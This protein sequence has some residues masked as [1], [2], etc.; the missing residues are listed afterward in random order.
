MTLLADG[1]EVARQSFFQPLAPQACATCSQV[2]LVP[3]DF[4]V[5]L[6]KV[7][8]RKLSVAIEVPHLKEFGAAFPL[9]QAGN[10]TINARLLLEET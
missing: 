10:P 9:K 5:D 2:P 1:E 3:I 6:D 8:G 4:R 7:Q